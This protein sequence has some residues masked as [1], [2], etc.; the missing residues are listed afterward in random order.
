MIAVPLATAVTKPPELTD[1]IAAL[2]VV[3]VPPV[4]ASANNEELPGQAVVV[5]VITP[6]VG[7]GLTVTDVVAEAEPQLFVTV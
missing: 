5:P 4:T 7:N 6:A 1:A 2:L 3:H